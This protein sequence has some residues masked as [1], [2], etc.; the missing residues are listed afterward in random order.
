MGVGGVACCAGAVRM[1]RSRP[2]ITCAWLKM[3]LWFA[4]GMIYV[5]RVRLIGKM[6]SPVPWIW[7]SGWGINAFSHFST[8]LMAQEI[9]LSSPDQM[10]LRMIFQLSLDLIVSM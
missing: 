5:G 3:R 9:N 6:G 7:T 2:L 8:A 10:T 4:F 1:S